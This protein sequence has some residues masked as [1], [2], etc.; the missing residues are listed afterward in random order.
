MSD[1]RAVTDDDGSVG[2][3]AVPEMLAQAVLAAAVLCAGE[4]VCA[5]L[6]FQLARMVVAL[7]PWALLACLLSSVFVFVPGFALLWCAE[8]LAMKAPH[9]AVPFVY[10]VVGMVGFGVWSRLVVV[11]V[12]DVVLSPFGYAALGTSDVLAVTVNGGALGFMAFFLASYLG[13]RFAAR[14]RGIIL[15]GVV[16]LLLTLAGAAVAFLMFSRLY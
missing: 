5:P 13:S 15:A 2:P 12:I 1:R 4:I 9:R 14:R 6:Y 8:S 3:G 10:A 16:T 11:S 7:V